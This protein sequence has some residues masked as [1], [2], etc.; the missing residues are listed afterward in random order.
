[1][2]ADPKMDL[3]T[4]LRKLRNLR[5]GCIGAASGMG[6]VAAVYV[7]RPATSLSALFIAVVALIVLIPVLIRI[8][9]AATGQRGEDS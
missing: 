9:S 4:R 7:G 2:T 1:M 8:R 5:N 6:V 3:E